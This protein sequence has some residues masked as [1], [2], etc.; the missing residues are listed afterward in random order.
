M[1]SSLKSTISQTSGLQT[2]GL[3][4]DPTFS[5]VLEAAGIYVYINM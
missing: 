1:T 4:W 3:P 2:P 5:A